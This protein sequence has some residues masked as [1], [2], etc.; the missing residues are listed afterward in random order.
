MFELDILKFVSGLH[1]VYKKNSLQCNFTLGSYLF[2]LCLQVYLFMFAHSLSKDSKRLIYDA[3]RSRE[4][5]AGIPCSSGAGRRG[6]D[7][8]QLH[9]TKRAF[10]PPLAIR[11]EA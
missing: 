11:N 6:F 10:F 7:P 1:H 4:I 8:R 3:H 5:K 2:Y 9:R